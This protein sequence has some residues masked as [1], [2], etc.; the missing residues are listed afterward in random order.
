MTTVKTIVLAVLCVLIGVLIDGWWSGN[1][2]RAQSSRFRTERYGELLFI[3][4]YNS[5]AGVDC[6][7]GMDRTGLIPV[8]CD[9]R[10]QETVRR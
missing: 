7:I 1:Q 8:A 9:R 2:V 5:V 3:R 10:D 6:Y 4:Y